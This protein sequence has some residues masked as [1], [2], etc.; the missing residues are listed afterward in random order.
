[1]IAELSQ[2]EPL[3]WLIGAVII[4]IISLASAFVM[5]I[6]NAPYIDGEDDEI[7]N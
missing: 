5:A 6:I 1:M 7:S 4:L 2:I 3:T